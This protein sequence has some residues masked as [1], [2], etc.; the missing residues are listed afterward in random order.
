MGIVKPR[1]ADA[2]RCAL[3][4]LNWLRFPAIALA[5]FALFILSTADAWAFK[6]KKVSKE[7]A[8]MS[9]PEYAVGYRRHS[10]KDGKKKFFHTVT[11]KDDKTIT[12]KGSGGCSGIRSGLF[13]PATEWHCRGGIITREVK[14]KG[15][16]IWPL[17]PPRQFLFLI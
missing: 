12:W 3:G 7:Q 2:M 10:V 14:F 11:A 13:A 17:N 15:S 9:K 8:P 6:E 1:I 4:W 5:L 16:D